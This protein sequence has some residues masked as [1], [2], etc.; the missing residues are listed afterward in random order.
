MRLAAKWTNDCQGKK[1]YDGSIVRITT[2][3]W[4]RGG[5]FT[6]LRGGVA[7]EKDTRP[8]IRPAGDS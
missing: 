5:G 3:Y 4:P 6:I 8:D 1:D 7:E 2:R